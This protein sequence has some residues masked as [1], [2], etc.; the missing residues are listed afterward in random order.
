[1]SAIPKALLRKFTAL[2]AYIKK[3]EKPQANYLS[4]HFKTR[5][6]RAKET[7]SKQK[8]EN[9][10]D[11]ISNQWSATRKIRKINEI[12]SWL[13]ENIKF[14]KSLGRGK[15]TQITSYQYW[16]WNRMNTDAADIKS[17]EILG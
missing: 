15:R 1:M 10:K 2:N 11:K 7:Q 12:N 13:F 9:N 8:E 5:K 14:D 17:K 16:E 6:R 4:S 3:E